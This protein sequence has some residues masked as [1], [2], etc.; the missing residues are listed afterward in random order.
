ME[1]SSPVLLLRFSFQ[2]FMPARVCAF[3]Y[4]TGWSVIKVTVNYKIGNRFLVMVGIHIWVSKSLQTQW[5]P[6]LLSERTHLLT[7][8]FRTVKPDH[9]LLS[10]KP[11]LV[12]LLPFTSAFFRD[13]E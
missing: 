3:I 8:K 11:E 1:Y 13:Y 5:E 9:S 7:E 4:G 10:V 6:S 12:P 2:N